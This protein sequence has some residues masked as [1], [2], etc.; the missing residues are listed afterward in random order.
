M[1]GSDA[2]PLV[3]VGSGAVSPAGW[4]VPSLLRAC[5]EA[6]AL[7]WE[8]R[9][10]PQ[11]RHAHRVRAV[12]PPVESFAWM[13]HPRLRRGSPLT[14][15]T[16]AA[17]LEALGD[18]RREAVS[19]REIRLGIIYVFMNGCVHYSNRFYREVLED[20]ALASPILFPE[21]VF[22]APA[23]HLAALLGADGRVHTLVGDSS[24]FL[25][26]VDLAIDWLGQDDIDCCL[27]VGGEEADWLSAE[28]AR[29]FA[30]ASV[31]GEGAG[32]LLLEKGQGSGVALRQITP[33]RSYA[34]RSRREAVTSMRGELPAALPES[35]LVSGRQGIHRL[36]RLESEAWGD[37][38][39]ARIDPAAIL[40]ET[41]GAA[42][43]LQSVLAHALV[44][45]GRYAH[46]LVSHAGGN[47]QA[48]GAW[49]EHG[50]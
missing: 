36:D 35:V 14:R 23:S 11:G 9:T 42:L 32:A 26:A 39:G 7:P 50:V 30:R 28:A 45:S 12:P 41:M 10:R 34:C 16:V 47:Q 48:V 5:L 4:G 20:P 13:R 24:Q 25:P 37:W 22:N 17:A 8:E 44:A 43:A 29:F 33:P 46:A 40:G 18:A 3:V 15:F 21:T 27:V 38:K 2:W 49:F 31:V 1:S 19:R 6:K